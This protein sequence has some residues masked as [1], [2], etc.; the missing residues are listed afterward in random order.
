MEKN[1]WTSLQ[2]AWLVVAMF[3]AYNSIQALDGAA[4]YCSGAYCERNDDCGAP[5]SCDIPNFTCL[6]IEQPRR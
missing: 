4:D 1:I 2:I 5:C 3:T 6:Q